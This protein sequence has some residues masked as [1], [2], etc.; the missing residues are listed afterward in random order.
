M[1]IEKAN[2]T[3]NNQVAGREQGD[4]LRQF[5][6]PYVIYWNPEH[7]QFYTEDE[8]MMKDYGMIIK[9]MI[10][11]KKTAIGLALP[12]LG[13]SRKMF[14]C[15]RNGA[16][17]VHINPKPYGTPDE[18]YKEVKHLEGCL[19]IPKQQFQTVRYD[20]IL[21]EYWKLDYMGELKFVTERLTGM[22]AIVYQH[23]YD[24]LEGSLVCDFVQETVIQSDLKM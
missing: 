8:N 22:D 15:R 23:E 10:I 21:V 13:I 20:P 19:S 1:R 9:E 16:N 17:I 11:R 6:Q 14:V 3:Y 12:Q 5:A 24:H 2:I 18:D 7:Q 4:I